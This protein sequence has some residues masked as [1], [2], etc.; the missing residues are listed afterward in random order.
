MPG[1]RSSYST[2]AGLF[3]DLFPV[4]L[5]LALFAGTAG[6][7]IAHP[8]A[9]SWS[10]GPT[11]RN[12]PYVAAAISLLLGW[13]FA[14]SR[15][16]F[17]SVLLVLM[18][19][20]L[21]RAFFRTGDTESGSAV[22]FL[23]SI[24]FPCIAALFYH[25]HERGILTPHGYIKIAIVCSIVVVM[26]L[27][28]RVD[29]LRRAVATAQ[30][31]LVRP[32]PGIVR[33]PMIGLVVFGVSAVCL[34]LRNGRESPLLGPILFVA[35]LF[36]FTGLNFESELWPEGSGRVVLLSFTAGAGLVMAW[37]VMESGWRHAHIDELTQLPGRRSLQ[38]HLAKLGSSYALAVLDLDHFKKINDRHGHDVGDQVLK[39]AAATMKKNSVG[40]AYRQGGEEFVIVCEGSDYDATVEAL[41]QLRESIRTRKFVV[42]ARSRP[43]KRP[44]KS[45]SSGNGERKSLAVSVSIGVARRN[46]K[47]DTPAEVLE[48]AD[49]ALYRAKKA[50]RNCLKATR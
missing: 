27:L 30:T 16:S 28:P 18:V 34:F 15:I 20:L 8:D 9:A 31:G 42:R 7:I 39:F 1:T 46:K 38:H 33:V 40:R 29:T 11:V 50:G 36:V 24:Y 25:L 35:L 17:L 21:D 10:V 6:L 4:I 3:K 2:H 23:S 44:E 49:R 26:V 5:P 22:I 45:R 19:Y 14:Q 12:L 32:G 43:R 41:D 37:G 47:F 48:A 13:F